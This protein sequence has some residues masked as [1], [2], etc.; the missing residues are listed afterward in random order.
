MLLKVSWEHHSVLTHQGHMEAELTKNVF[1]GP[2][3]SHFTYVESQ[4]E[5]KKYKAIKKAWELK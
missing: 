4:M 2:Y 1:K 5:G 3:S